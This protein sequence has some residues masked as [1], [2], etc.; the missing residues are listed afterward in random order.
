M[1]KLF[2]TLEKIRKNEEASSA[3]ASSNKREEKA[4]ATPA[5]KNP[6]LMNLKRFIAMAAAIIFVLIGGYA[7]WLQYKPSHRVLPETSTVTQ[8]AVSISVDDQTTEEP[9]LPLQPEGDIASLDDSKDQADSQ[10]SL[11]ENHEDVEPAADP[12]AAL[13]NENASFFELNNLG[14]EQ[15]ALL[16]YWQGIYYLQKASDVSPQSIEPIINIAVAY[17]ELGLHKR[18]MDY[19]RRAYELDP[20]NLDLLDNL[21]ILM[22]TG[23]LDN[24]AL[25]SSFPDVVLPEPEPDDILIETQQ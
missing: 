11:A 24:Q 23:L 22:K 19:F 13:L 17:T 20:A 5:Q 15:V 2:E 4:P 1:S 16:D 7:A 14:V 12:G 3:V 25:V 10:N 8:S 6:N 9:P 21:G 18:A